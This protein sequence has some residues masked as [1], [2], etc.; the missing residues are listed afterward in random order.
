[1]E[2]TM[3]DIKSLVMKEL[4]GI[5]KKGTMS[6]TE[7][8]TAMDAVCLLEKIGR[9]EYMDDYAEE[10][11]SSGRY[12]PRYNT[13]DGGR[14]MNG[15][16]YNQGGGSYG[17]YYER[18]RSGHSIKDRMIDKIERMM[19]EAENDYERQQLERYIETIRNN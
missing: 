11:G 7:L 17:G 5:V 15:M 18:G 16:H 3:E 13:Y 12:W 19:G 10:E 2:R 1:M 6:P 4:D 14:S 9:V 8:K